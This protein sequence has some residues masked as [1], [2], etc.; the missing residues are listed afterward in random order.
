MTGS[1]EALQAA[2][3]L[4]SRQIRDNP[5][6]E[7]PE[8]VPAPSALNALAGGLTTCVSGFEHVHKGETLEGLI[9]W[10]TG[11]AMVS[12][13]VGGSSGDWLWVWEGPR[14]RVCGGEGVVVV[15]GC[16]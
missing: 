12:R 2:L 13:R 1:V 6:K 5:P 9:P 4:V 14:R 16:V 7:R 3:R 15:G 10:A 11:E 8:P